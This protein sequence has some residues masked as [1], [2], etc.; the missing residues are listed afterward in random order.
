LPAN[1]VIYSHQ[2]GG[3]ASEH[4]LTDFFDFDYFP[5]EEAF[6]HTNLNFGNPKMIFIL[7]D[8]NWPAGSA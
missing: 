1:K 8:R 5:V 2:S 7:F 3:I 6:I 4:R